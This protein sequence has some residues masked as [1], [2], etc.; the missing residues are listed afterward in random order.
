MKK[1]EF[2]IK[3]FNQIREEIK[4]SVSFCLYNNQFISS[5]KGNFDSLMKAKELSD[6]SLGNIYLFKLGVIIF[7]ILRQ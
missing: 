7:V 4:N 3:K 2:I 1:E 6:L 5:R